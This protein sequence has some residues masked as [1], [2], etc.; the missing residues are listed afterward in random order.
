MCWNF[1]F[2]RRKLVK[3][4]HEEEDEE[5]TDGRFEEDQESLVPLSD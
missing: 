1:A 5:R 2:T 3:K 4:V